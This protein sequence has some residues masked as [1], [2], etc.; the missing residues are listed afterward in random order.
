MDDR[1]RSE[2]PG[3]S[4]HI[5]WL[6]RR[7][8]FGFPAGVFPELIERLRGLPARLEERL[9]PLSPETLTRRDGPDW[10]IQEHAG[11]LHDLDALVAV[12]LDDYDAGRPVLHAADMS[13]QR[14]WEAQHNQRPIAEV[15]AGLRCDRLAIVAQLEALPAVAFERS[16]VHPR[17]E[18]PMRL[19]DMLFFQA[20]HD[21][22]HLARIS[23]LLRKFGT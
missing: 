16:A 20:E 2:L 1:P 18:A 4:A 19:A 17:L 8:D 21:D 7:F 14:T 6:E 23:D 11:H 13:N 12:R 5:D 15:L 10:S 3:A 22:Y 9:L